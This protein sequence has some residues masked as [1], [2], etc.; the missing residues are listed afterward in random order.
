MRKYSYTILLSISF[1]VMAVSW[2]AGFLSPIGIDPPRGQY[3]EAENDPKTGSTGAAEE[4]TEPAAAEEEPQ[5][6]EPE[7]IFYTADRDYFNDALFIGD[8][9]TMGLWEYGNLGQAEVFADTGMSVYKIL[10]QEFM[11]RDGE[12]RTLEGLLSEYSYK[13]IYVMLGIN[14]Q[15]YDFDT[16][17]ERYRQLIELIQRL[18]PDTILFLE[19]NL[20]IT[21]EESESDSVHT[22][23]N[24]DRFN[25]AVSQMADG[26]RVFYLDV[27][28][29]FDDEEGNL[30][31]QYTADGA[32]VFAKYYRVW[33]SWIL[34]HAVKYE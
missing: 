32:H 22:N 16:T 7:P 26:K 19:A 30:A 24:I 34:T 2:Q 12:K 11:C 15:G 13:K 4:Q 23:E 33:S 29:L 18:Q 20:H 8:S 21:K 5:E 28:S 14:E 6:K 3:K 9:R 1:L 31:V 17:V 10:K 27:N 25:E